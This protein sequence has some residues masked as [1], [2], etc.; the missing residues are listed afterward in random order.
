ML[1]QLDE[2]PWTDLK[3]AYGPAGNV[4][5]LLRRITGADPDDALDALDELRG[6]VLH[7]GGV[8]SATVPTVPFLAEL[9]TDPAIEHR[10]GIAYL[11]GDMADI[12]DSANPLLA[13]LR[14]AVTAQ[15]DRL[16]PLLS[17]PD[18]WTR[19]AAGFALARCPGRAAGILAELRARW[20]VEPDP[21]VRGNLVIAATSLDPRTELL[22]DALAEG[23]PAA[24]R[25]GAAAAIARCGLAWPGLAVDAVR[26]GWA[27]GNPWLGLDIGYPWGFDPIYDLVNHLTAAEQPAVVGA[28]LASADPGVRQTA[29][30]A[31]ASLIGQFRSVREPMVLVLAGAFDDPAP[32]VRESAVRGIRWAG[33]AAAV[34]ADALAAMAE[35]HDDASAGGALAALVEIGDPRWRGHLPAR[36]AAGTAAPDTGTV[37]AA[38]GAPPEPGLLDAVRQRLTETPEP[39]RTALV[40]LLGSWGTAAAA[41]VGELVALLETGRSPAPVAQAL[42]AIGPAAEP[43]V[44]A[45]RDRATSGSGPERLAAARAVWRLTGDPEPALDAAIQQIDADGWV[46]QAVELLADVGDPARRLVPRLRD[47]LARPPGRSLPSQHGRVWLARLVGRWTGDREAVLAAALAVAERGWPEARA[48]AAGL[49]A[50][51]GDPTGLDTLRGLLTEPSSAEARLIAAQALWRHTADAEPLLAPAMAVLADRPAQRVLI[52]VLDLFT[53]L[54]PAARPALPA[55]RRLADRDPTVVWYAAEANA[56]SLDEAYR[57]TIR[58]VVDALER[59]PQ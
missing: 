10:G 23:Q 25:A 51:L 24:V 15:V 13:E 6:S 21:L 1:D 45:L 28:L 5:D 11:L 34:A 43:A 59:E 39:E 9:L 54:G 26:A 47:A 40:R 16:M 53:A 35:R 31:G 50:E 42:A 56:G 7:Q 29:A 4:P 37:L 52:R 12:R 46:S 55:L 19:L 32:E 48:E 57:A 3:H 20:P 30:G 58:A 14:E 17:A 36:I 44:P 18:P 38:A 49:A 33:P 8:C 22:A 2:V 41:A 27:D